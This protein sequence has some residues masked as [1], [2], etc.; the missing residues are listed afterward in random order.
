MPNTIKL[1]SNFTTLLD[2]VYR[3]ASVTTDLNTNDATIQAG[4]NA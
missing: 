1:A 2:E 3:A 4:A